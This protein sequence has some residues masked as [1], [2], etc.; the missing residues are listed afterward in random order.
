LGAFLVVMGLVTQPVF[1]C[2]ATRCSKK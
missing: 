2:V 1:K